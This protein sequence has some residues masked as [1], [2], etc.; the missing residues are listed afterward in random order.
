MSDTSLKTLLHKISGIVI[1]IAVVG[2]LT[3]CVF[4]QAE[5]AARIELLKEI[6][7][8]SCKNESC[9]LKWE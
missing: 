4:N 9:V 1:L 6:E 8:T 2:N 7:N 3:T 5:S